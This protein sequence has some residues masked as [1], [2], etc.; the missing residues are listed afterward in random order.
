MWKPFTVIQI[1]LLIAAVGVII[2]GYVKYG[3]DPVIA[4]TATSQIVHEYDRAGKLKKIYRQLPNWENEIILTVDDEGNI[5]IRQPD[6]DLA[7]GE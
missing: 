5:L 1:I 4:I 6:D 2:W 7:K 3:K